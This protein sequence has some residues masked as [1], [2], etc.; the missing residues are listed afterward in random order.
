MCLVQ[1]LA[2]LAPLAFQQHPPGAPAA[3]EVVAGPIATRI[4][5]FLGRLAGFD[6]NGS[7]LIEQKGEVVL[8][9]GYGY[10][11]RASGR[12]YTADTAFDIGSLAKQF[13][14][15]AVLELER[16]G[17]LALDDPLGQFFPEAPADKI[18][19]TLEQLLTHTAGLA[20]D[21]PVSDPATPDYDDVDAE[22]ALR[23]ILAQP[24]ELRPGASWSYSNCG[25][26]LLAAVVQTV[27]GRDFRELVRESLFAPAGMRHTG[28]WG[29]AHPADCPVALGQDAFGNVLHDPAR[30]RATWFDLGGGEV[31]STLDDLRAWIA[32]LKDTTVLDVEHVARLFEPRTGEVSSRDGRYA[33]GW[34]VQATPRGTRQ[35]HH[36]GDYL[37]TGAWLRWFPDDDVLVVSSTAVR[38]DL[39]PTQNVVQ[40]LLQKLIF[41]GA[42]APEAPGFAALDAPPPPELEGAYALDTGGRLLLRRIHG[43]LYIGAEG[44]DATDALAAS[45]PLEA[46]RAWCSREGLAAIEGA[47]RR[48]PAALEAVLGRDPNPAF[49]GLLQDELERLVKDHGGLRRVTLL[50]TFATGWPHGNP[51]STET[52][53]IRLECAKD[54]VVEAIRWSG[55]AIA[56]TEEVLIPLACC[57]PLQLAADGSWVG[58]KIL[59][60]QPLRV[61]P[62]DLDGAPGI[63]LDVAGRTT[64]ARRR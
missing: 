64:R 2:L 17:E 36:G 40:R 16:R 25:F 47:L 22:T 15:A 32:A 27:S 63:E 42:A 33:Y 3:S 24:L 44:Q 6:Y 53:L 43:R 11:D 48:E 59:E 8:R 4:D 38:H 50:G 49:A 45:A 57:V 12:L 46:E 31:W 29:S 1:G 56:W 41:E 21:F 62:L 34:F 9:K 18:D 23:R 60:A 55:R 61:R 39:Y 58:W 28:F 37:G 7:I 51:L 26:V 5:A 30:M 52:T 19:I 54:D 13:T 35:I 10:A 20:S 14:A